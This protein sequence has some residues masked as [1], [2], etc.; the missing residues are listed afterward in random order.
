MARIKY[1]K[2]LLQ[3]IVKESRSY[4]QVLKKLGLKQTGGSYSHISKKIKQYD[5]DTSHFKGQSWSKGKKFPFKY[6][7]EDYLNNKKFIPSD[8]LKKRL[9]KE[10]YFEHKCYHCGMTEWLGQ[11]IPIELH[12]KDH[13]HANNNLDNLEI[14]CP[15]CHA[16]KHK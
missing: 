1:S 10:N 14:L 8:R 12:H 11:H 16:L 5:I 3:S 13:D 6:P 15:N 7:I 2:E 4:A 9:I